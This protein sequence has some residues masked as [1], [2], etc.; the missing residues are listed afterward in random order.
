[1]FYGRVKIAARLLEFSTTTEKLAWHTERSFNTSITVSHSTHNARTSTGSVWMPDILRR[2]RCLRECPLFISRRTTMCRFS[3]CISSGR[4]G[5]PARSQIDQQKN[6]RSYDPE[7]YGHDPQSRVPT[8]WVNTLPSI[9]INP[10]VTRPSPGRR[11]D[12]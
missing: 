2:A 7:I 6:P 4:G 1:M 9:A 8:Y 11:Q 10:H 5:S 3:T 12:T